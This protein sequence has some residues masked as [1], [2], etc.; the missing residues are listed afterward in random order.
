M[1]RRRAYKTV[2]PIRAGGTPRFEKPVRG[3]MNSLETKLSERLQELQDSGKIKGWWYEPLRL[4]LGRRTTLTP[5]FAVWFPCGRLELYEAKGFWTDDALAKTKIAAHLFQMWPIMVWK[6]KS[7]Q[8][9]G[10]LIRPGDVL[11]QPW[12]SSK[13]TRDGQALLGRLREELLTGQISQ[14]YCRPFALTATQDVPDFVAMRG[15]TYE[16]HFARKASKVDANWLRA[17]TEA[18]PWASVRLLE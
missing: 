12:S 5:D 4:Y 9:K 3:Q 13:L 18:A 10:D 6:H 14:F 2:S 16:L 1:R 17:V 8:W 11:L 7:K 15:E